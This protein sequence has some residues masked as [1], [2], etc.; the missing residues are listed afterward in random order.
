ML[1]A[2]RF[3]WKERLRAA[4]IHLAI[5]AIVAALAAVLVFVIWYPYPYR[6]IS[7]GRE[8]FLILTA[9][10]VVLGPLITF[11]IFNR[12]K[13]W[14]VLRR[15][16]VIVGLTQLAALAFGLWTVFEAR[17]V[18]LAFEFN[19]FR[20]VHAIEVP[21]SELAKAASQWRT[22]PLLGPQL[23]AVRPFR[24]A[25]E[26]MSATMMAVSGLQLSAQ[27]NLWQAYAHARRRVLDESRPVSDLRQ[28]FADRTAEIDAAVA[29]TGLAPASVR[30]MP[31]VGRKTFWTVLLDPQSADVVGFIPLD[32]F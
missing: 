7:G 14:P 17:P 4:S 13:R 16:L 25:T 30:Y 22:L 3:N 1:D 2:T 15:D 26:N 20:V 31:M 6:E 29:R 9:V 28:R 5:S 10:D 24:D 21:R 8:L 27:P 23:I 32:S 12:A 19:R 11:A 18:Y